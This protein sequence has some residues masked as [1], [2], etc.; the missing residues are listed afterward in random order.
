MRKKAFLEIIRIGFVVT[1][2]N[3]EKDPVHDS[4]DDTASDGADPVHLMKTIKLIVKA[5]GFKCES[6]P[7]I[8]PYA[9]DHGWP[10][11]SG[12]IHAGTGELN[13]QIIKLNRAHPTTICI[14]NL[15]LQDDQL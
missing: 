6:Y 14:V 5:I 4:G 2:P 1:F 10:E 8:C 9:H 15:R 3:F 11:A 12:W 7:L 13:L